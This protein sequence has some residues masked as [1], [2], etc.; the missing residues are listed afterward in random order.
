MKINIR[1]LKNQRNMKLNGID[2]LWLFKPVVVVGFS[3]VVDSS[4]VVDG[5]KV[6]IK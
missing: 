3:V 6:K 1:E 2:L 4:V 5:S